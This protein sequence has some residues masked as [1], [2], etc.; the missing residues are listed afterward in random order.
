[1]NDKKNAL[2]IVD[3]KLKGKRPTGRTRCR[4]GDNIKINLYVAVCVWIGLNWLYIQSPAVDF[5]GVPCTGEIAG[6]HVK[7][8]LNDFNQI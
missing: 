5:C 1:M 8:M 4:W 3:R 7:C 6:L 2:G